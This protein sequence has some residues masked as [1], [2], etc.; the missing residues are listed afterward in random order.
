VLLVLILVAARLVRDDIRQLQADRAERGRALTVQQRLMAL[1]ICR[2]TVYRICREGRLHHVRVSNSI[3]VPERA[4]ETF[5]RS[6][7]RS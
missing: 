1:G 2:A 5:L 6:S 3:R 7:E 4:L